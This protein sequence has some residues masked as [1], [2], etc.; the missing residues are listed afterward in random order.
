MTRPAFEGAVAYITPEL[1]RDTLVDLVN[2][3]SPT[4]QES[5]V[6]RYLVD[7]MRDAGLN[8][9]LPGGGEPPQRGRASARARQE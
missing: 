2:I 7:R 6:A 5:G 1:V 4:G 3:A 9:D 8:T